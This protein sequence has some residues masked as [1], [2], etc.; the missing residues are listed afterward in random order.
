GVYLEGEAL[1]EVDSRGRPIVDDAFLVL[2]NA[3]HEPVPFRMPA[4]GPGHWRPLVDT[5][6][7]TGLAPDGTYEDGDWYS[8]QGRALVLLLHVKEPSVTEAAK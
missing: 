1:D 5:V 3:H 2:F 6:E 4:V 8:L 7:P